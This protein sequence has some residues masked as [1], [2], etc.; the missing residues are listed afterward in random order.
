MSDST[1]TIAAS[2]SNGPLPQIDRGFLCRIVIQ[3]DSF[4][5]SLPKFIK[6][7]RKTPVKFEFTQITNL[8]SISVYTIQ[9]LV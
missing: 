2:L 4:Q 5:L 1:V 8:I 3:T 9:Y 7:R 6:E